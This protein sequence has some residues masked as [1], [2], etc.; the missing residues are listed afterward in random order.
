SLSRKDARDFSPEL[1]RSYATAF[2]FVA[3]W[4]F[5][6]G[7]RSVVMLALSLRQR[8]DSI[9]PYVGG[10]LGYYMYLYVDPRNGNPFYVGKG[11]H[12]RALAHLWD[13]SEC[14]KVALIKEIQASSLEPRIDIL[15]HSRCSR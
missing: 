3:I 1:R 2:E 10:K 11:Q 7:R 13:T 5:F 15:P 8:V 4:S 6:P 9:A 12:E 14:R